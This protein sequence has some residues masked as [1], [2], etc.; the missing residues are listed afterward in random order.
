MF[1]QCVICGQDVVWEILKV[2]ACDYRK[3]N[4]GRAEYG[5]ACSKFLAKYPFSTPWKLLFVA[6]ENATRL[7]SCEWAWYL[8]SLW[9]KWELIPGYGFLIICQYF[10]VYH[11]CLD[12]RNLNLRVS[13]IQLNQNHVACSCCFATVSLEETILAWYD[14]FLTNCVLDHT[15]FVV[16]NVQEIGCL[17]DHL[18]QHLPRDWQ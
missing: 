14:L 11:I 7:E 4:C 1:F 9:L 16:W 5:V 12:Y 18:F 3:S 2:V 13:K 15:G 6:V 17:S 10:G 8:F